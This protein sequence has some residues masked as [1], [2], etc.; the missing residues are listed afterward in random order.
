MTIPMWIWSLILLSFCQLVA[1]R[2]FIP[3]CPYEYYRLSELYF[4]IGVESLDSCKLPESR[5]YDES[6]RG[7]FLFAGAKSQIG[8][9]MK[10]PSGG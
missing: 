3:S 8:C 9:G 5:N 4:V 1:R 2:I 10:K 6:E 7:N